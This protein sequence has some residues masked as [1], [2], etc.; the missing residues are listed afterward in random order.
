MQEVNDHI[1]SVRTLLKPIFV[2]DRERISGGKQ[3]WSQ[4]ENAVQALEKYGRQQV[5]AVVERINEMIVARKLI[6]DAECTGA[7]IE[8]EPEIIPKGSRFDF[9]VRNACGQTTFIEVK[10]VH[11]NT[12]DSDEKW[13]QFL[14]RK[15]RISAGTEYVACK[16]L[17]GAAIAG[18]SFSA[19]SSFM[20]YTRETEV[21]LSEH[22]KIR[23]GK[24]VL[25][26][27]GNGFGWH[28]SELEDFADFYHSG[29]H[30]VDD[31]FA[32]MESHSM[33]DKFALLGNL[34]GFAASIRPHDAL[35]PL[36]WVYPVRGSILWR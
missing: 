4:F 2:C 19:R 35:E 13:E 28:L 18:N 3:L 16:S 31:P 27:C 14:S 33:K 20:K 11:P 15:D 21:K 30:R 23:P 6:T 29:R 7:S 32:E 9:V 5:T 10:T 34:D 1:S 24:A 25:V 26:F 8:Y 12:D 36:N 17:M 22:V